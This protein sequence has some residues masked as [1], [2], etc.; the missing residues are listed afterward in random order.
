VWDQK[1]QT[2]ED[3]AMETATM[4]RVLAKAKFESLKRRVPLMD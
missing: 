4:G 1:V 2:Q 3:E